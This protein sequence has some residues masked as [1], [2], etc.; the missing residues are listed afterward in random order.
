MQQG[1][2]DCFSSSVGGPPV[3]VRLTLVQSSRD[4]YKQGGSDNNQT[5][6]SS[7][8]QREC[9]FL[10]IGIGGGRVMTS[11]LGARQEGGDCFLI[12]E[13]G[14][15]VS[16]PAYLLG[17]QQCGHAYQMI[18]QGGSN[19]LRQAFLN[20]A[21]QK[22]RGYFE[23]MQGGSGGSDIINNS[24]ARFSYAWRGGRD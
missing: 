20:W 19:I 14:R 3:S 15:G 2:R 5:S 16:R 22:E 4:T 6:L 12:A 8:W 9:V 1:V 24:S 17:N 18:E 11:L 10:E 23:V 7:S 21:R 13:S